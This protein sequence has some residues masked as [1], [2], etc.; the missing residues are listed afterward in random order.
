MF[1]SAVIVAAGKGKRMYID[2]NKQYVEIEGKPIIARTLQVFEECGMIDEIILVVNEQDIIYCK[3]NII[4]VYGFDKVKTLACGG[5]ERQN[6][7]Y[8]GLAQVSGGCEIVLI[9]DGARPFVSEKC[10]IDSINAAEKHG[11]ACLA[12]PVKDTIKVSDEEGFVHE[13]L[14]RSTL[15]SVQTPQTFKYEIIMQ[16]HKKALDEG[17][18][19]T[20]DAVLVERMGIR[21]KLVMGSYDNIKITTQ[22][23]LLMA[24]LIARKKEY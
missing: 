13:T 12:V 1:T 6:S 16:A 17:F 14:D 5:E 19:G 24:E 11:A 23:D 21:S 9:H 3:K 2:M 8:N 10:I 15:W 4:D 22:E 7:V 20:D 18:R